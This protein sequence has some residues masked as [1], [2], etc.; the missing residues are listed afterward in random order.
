MKAALALLAIAAAIYGWAVHTSLLP[1]NL[2]QTMQAMTL[3]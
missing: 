3:C 2:L 1:A